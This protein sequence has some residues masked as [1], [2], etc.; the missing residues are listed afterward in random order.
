MCVSC[1]YARRGTR[2]QNVSL[3]HSTE[4]SSAQLARQRP[5]LR[6]PGCVLVAPKLRPIVRKLRRPRGETSCQTVEGV[7]GGGCAGLRLLAEEE[8]GSLSLWTKRK[9]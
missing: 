3:R 5:A 2:L 1:G 6:T 4:S 8:A 9:K 7:R